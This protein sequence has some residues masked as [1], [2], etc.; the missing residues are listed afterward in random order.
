MTA[1]N[2]N[3]ADKTKSDAKSPVG[4][5]PLMKNKVQ[6]LPLRYGL[7]ERLDPSAALSLPYRLKSRPLGIRLI[8]DGWL[9]VIDNETGYLHEYRVENGLVSKFVWKGKEAAQDKRTGTIAE[10]CLVF[11]RNS[12]LHV[13]FS[14]AQWTAFKCSQMIKSREDRDLFMQRI[15]LA[16]ADCD[17]GGTH[18]LT[19]AQTEKW[20]AE[21]A[22][23]A[24]DTAA[25]AGANP[26][27]G[28]DY[29][30]EHAQLFR[31]AQLGELKKS[32]S[33]VYENDHFFLVLKDSIGVMRD[34]AEEQDT[35]VNWLEE[36]SGQQRQELKYVIGSYI[37]TLMVVSDDT[38]K[39]A[40]VSSP[41]F[42]KT[43]PAQRETVYDYINARNELTWEQRSNP[44]QVH[45]SGRGYAPNPE[46]SAARS[47]AAVKKRTMIDALGEELYD[48]LADDIENL[49][50]QS[51]ATL[52][53][54]GLGSR[55][56]H[57]LVRH[58]EMKQYLAEERSHM[59]RWLARLDLITEDRVEL[60]TRQE[61]HL[62]AWYYD[63]DQPN[64]LRDALVV[65]QNCTRDI[66]RTEESLV[67]VGEYFHTYPYYVLPA[68]QTQLTSAFLAKQAQK[69]IK[70]LE[71]VKGYQKSLA[72]ALQ[73]QDDI[74]EILGVHWTKSL[75]LAPQAQ[76]L[77]LLVSTT[78]IPALSSRSDKWLQ[79]AKQ[80]HGQMQDLLD[81]LDN[82]SNRGQRLGH[83]LALR[84]Q[85]AW[86]DDPTDEQFQRYK[87]D[88]QRFIALLDSEDELVR[89]RDQAQRDSRKR[90]R[91]AAER[92]RSKAQKQQYN[93]QLQ[94]LAA[95]R[96][97]LLAQ[98]E[99]GISPTS[100]LES[101]R[102]G[103]RIRGLDT[104]QQ[105]LLEN[106]IRR[107][108]SGQIGG[109]ATQGTY[110][111]AFKS[112]WLPSLLLYIQIR[113][114]LAAINTYKD[115]GNASFKDDLILIGS[116]SGAM[117]AGLSIYQSAHIV[118]IN[119]VLKGLN[120]GSQTR[121]GALFA[122][123]LGK[124]GLALGTP[125]VG[126][127]ALGA[128]GTT[129]NNWGKWNEAFR[130][131]TA[132]ERTGAVMAFYGDMGVTTTSGLQTARGLKDLWL[133]RQEATGIMR[134]TPGMTYKAARAAAWATRGPRFMTYMARLSP[135]G[136]AFTALQIVGETVYNYHHLDAL[137][138]WMLHCC[139]G[140]KESPQWN[141]ERHYQLLAEATLQPVIQDL[142]MV[143]DA[144]TG[145]SWRTLRLSLPGSRLASLQNHTLHWAVELQ[146]G[147]A[148]AEDAGVQLRE[149]IRLAATEPLALDLRLPADWLDGQSLLQ[150]LLAYQ[151]E[152]ANEPIHAAT[153]YLH[154]RI[155]LDI[156]IRSKPVTATHPSPAPSATQLSWTP[157]TPEHLH[158]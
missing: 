126:L 83:L 107:M 50:D 133:L 13:C 142:G 91:T 6:L 11:P 100:S 42:E 1:K 62:S 87:S 72:N 63:F 90:T 101:G 110:K 115:L 38:A 55:G 47:K 99:Q 138:R 24:N 125:I 155:P 54:Q 26:Q 89:Q 76:Q 15:D 117:S 25:P 128:L 10:P 28:Q 131:G 136:L 109:Y 84:Q 45:Y 111:A 148:P 149:C 134:Q 64:Q 95:E 92:E 156:A 74:D 129:L 73:R 120:T 127:T 158:G 8:R 68:F 75:N 103:L 143:K 3:L 122:V 66:C 49:E 78:Y 44:E 59:K 37:E 96:N 5:C 2:P 31:A 32:L 53:G 30:W 141:L 56:L 137:Q 27:E 114:A 150:L 145:D 61:F 135:W 121:S 132:G 35:V 34:L 77:S 52:E 16:S 88:M 69:L 23:P 40:G 46:L 67:E 14:E 60:F 151:P 153:G 18:L 112:A 57:D 93:Q 157:I 124:L 154:Y 81:E 146:Q 20:L 29:C 48:E 12:T 152:M 113:N 43:T 144:S 130:T 58:E 98:L 94:A 97:A 51:H 116:L 106:E 70:W 105:Q 7:V 36:W 123:R 21:I 19:D 85:G 22:E 17:K 119:E 139:W 86:L 65:E 140:E 82:R 71:K 9:Y 118:M 4:A 108:R 104:S 33:P 39:Q 41:F 80:Q 147:N 102:A 79:N